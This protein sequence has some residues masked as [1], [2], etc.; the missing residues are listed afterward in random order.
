MTNLS[1][2]TWELFYQ[3][4]PIPSVSTSPGEGQIAQEIHRLLAQLPLFQEQPKTWSRNG[5]RERPMPRW[6]RPLSRAKAGK[7]CS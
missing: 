5:Y 2:R 6:W 3:L 1:Q 4:C 7:R